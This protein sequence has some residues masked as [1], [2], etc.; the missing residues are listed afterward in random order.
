MSDFVLDPVF[1]REFH[2]LGDLPL[3]RVLLMDD[4]RYTWLT[5]VP[6]RAGIVE[7]IDLAPADRQQAFEET[8]LVS[9]VIRSVAAPDKLNVGALGN[10]VRQLHIHIIARFASDPAWPGPVWGHSPRVPYPPHQAGIIIDRLTAALA[11]RG[12]KGVA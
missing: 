10:M 5:L 8:M 1:E 2:P 4:A 6:R 7:I 3:S 11:A 12:M 9:E